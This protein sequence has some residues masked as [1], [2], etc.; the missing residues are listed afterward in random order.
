MLRFTSRNK[1]RM[2]QLSDPQMEYFQHADEGNAPY[3]D[4]V[5]GTLAIVL[6]CNGPAAPL[7]SAYAVN[8]QYRRAQIDQRESR[9]EFFHFPTGAV[10]SIGLISQPVLI[11]PARSLPALSATSAQLYR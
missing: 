6:P 1:N 11:I 5:Y 4:R 8:I 10:S 7:K 2:V 9:R 3:G